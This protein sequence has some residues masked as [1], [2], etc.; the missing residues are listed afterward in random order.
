MDLTDEEVNEII[1]SP[2]GRPVLSRARAKEEMEARAAHNL[3]MRV[4]NALQNDIGA[5]LTEALICEFHEI[6][7]RDIDYRGNTYPANT[8]SARS[9]WIR[10]SHQNIRRSRNS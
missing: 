7:T 4:E 10:T 9:A 8:G 6:L 2:D 1:S 5:Q 3:F